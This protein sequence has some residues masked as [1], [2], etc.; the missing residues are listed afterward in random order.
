RAPW[1]TSTFERARVL[2]A[3]R[4][5]TEGSRRDPADRRRFDAL[6]AAAKEVVLLAPT[7][8]DALSVH[9]LREAIQ[10]D[11]PSRLSWALGYE[12]ALEANIGGSYLQRRARGLEAQVCRL[13]AESGEAFDHAYA[14]SVQGV[15][16]WFAGEWRAAE[17]ALRDAIHL[18]A[19]LPNPSA[20]ERHVLESFWVGALEAQG[21]L[22]EL[23]ALVAELRI[24][25]EQTGHVHAIAMCKLSAASLPALARDRA[26]DAIADADA[27]ISGWSNDDFT[28]IRFQHCVVSVSARLYAGHAA[29]AFSQIEQLWQRTSRNY[30]LRLDSVGVMLRQLRGRAALAL[31]RESSASEAERLKKIANKEAAAIGGSR[32]LHA[33]ALER[34]IACG[35]AS[36]SGDRDLARRHCAEALAGFDLAEMPLMREIARHHHAELIEDAMERRR[37]RERS[38]AF[39]KHVGVENPSAMARSWFP[40]A[41]R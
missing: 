2:L 36:L 16:A 20:H 12:A 32:S 3:P 10:L 40:I 28:P 27:A 38:D 29:Q 24:A 18:Y 35:V 31:A 7:A 8:G 6:W 9:A 33:R 11:D 34:V 22:P 41:P 26:L 17:T 37:A 1:I 30:F 25:A 5:A 19:R 15:V 14:R 21:K 39:M 23:N 4:R 13:A